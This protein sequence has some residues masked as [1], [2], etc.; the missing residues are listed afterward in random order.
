[1]PQ[2]GAVGAVGRSHGR[3][4]PTASAATVVASALTCA[5][6]TLLPA[7]CAGCGRWETTLCA[8]CRELLSGPGQEVARADGAGDLGVLVAADYAGPVRQMV[9][10]WKNGRREDLE[11]P[12]TEAAGRVASQWA[13]QLDEETLADLRGGRGLLVVP[14]PSG[15][16]RRL[17]GRLV[18]ARLADAVALQAAQALAQRSCSVLVVSAD[19][20]RRRG[21]VVSHQAG[22]SARGRR[23][24]PARRVRVLA[25]VAGWRVL[26]V[27]DVVTTGATIGACARALDA[28]GA[29]CVGGLALAAPPPP[30]SVENLL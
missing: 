26:V 25:P 19:V 8:T 23:A 5:A 20:L 21:G 14:A 2:P 16:W 11:A 4:R 12:L 15:A 28:A 30:A 6:R 17:R 10:A 22:R 13:R 7:T 27:D 29:V 9:L 18:A 1:M 24:A 3:E